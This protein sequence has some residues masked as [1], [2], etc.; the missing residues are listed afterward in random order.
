MKEETIK[1]PVKVLH[2]IRD[3]IQKRDNKIKEKDILLA[4]IGD[5]RKVF[6][7]FQNGMSQIYGLFQALNDKNT[8]IETL[9]K[10]ERD[11]DFEKLVREVVPLVLAQ[12]PTPKDG[13][14][15]KDGLP[16]KNA[17]E[18]RIIQIV[19]SQFPK[20]PTKEEIIASL[21]KVENGKDA[22]VDEDKIVEDLITRLKKKKEIDISQIRNADQFMFGGKKYKFE[23]LLHGGGGSSTSVITYSID[24]SAQADGANKIFTVPANTAFI[25]LTGTDAPFIYRPVID[26]TGTGT[27][28]LTIDAL[29]NAPSS[30]STLILTYKN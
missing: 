10:K 27:T 29:V 17:N 5:E 13:I 2:D 19:M 6:N 23:E 14:N 25:L 9:V 4:E 20:V 26:Y 7:E 24:L 30:G 16:G 15:G 8:N 28:T 18:E 12:V 1:I 3:E 22:V 21:P 11:L